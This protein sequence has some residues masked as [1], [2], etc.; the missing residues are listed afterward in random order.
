M[1]CS[2]ILIN[3]TIMPYRRPPNLFRHRS[4]PSASTRYI[5][6][7]GLITY[8]DKVYPR[9]PYLIS[10]TQPKIKVATQFGNNPHGQ[11]EGLARK[12]TRLFRDER[13]VLTSFTSAQAVRPHV[14]RLIVEA[15]RYGDRHRPTMAL[16]NFWLKDKALIHKLFKEL[17]PRY[18]NYSSAFTAIHRL[19]YDYSLSAKT[20]TELKEENRGPLKFNGGGETIIELR[21]NNLPPVTR[22]HENRNDLLTNVLIGSARMNLK[23]FSAKKAIEA[24]NGQ[25]Q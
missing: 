15:M 5:L 10:K 13:L 20:M 17:V 24:A 14:D 21:G 18:E 2:K 23:H 4:A 3:L 9:L 11:L 7:E 19:G 22:P 8:S 12:V 25:Q 16:A 1:C 6:N